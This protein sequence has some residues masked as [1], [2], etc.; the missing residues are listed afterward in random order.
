MLIALDDPST[1]FLDP[2]E[3]RKLREEQDGV[4]QGIGA[5]LAIV[6]QRYMN[7]INRHQIRQST[8]FPLNVRLTPGPDGEGSEQ[9]E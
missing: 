4:Y 5:T 8:P 7:W 6:K 1:R 9:D 2:A 3:K